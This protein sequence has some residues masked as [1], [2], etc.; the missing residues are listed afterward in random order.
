MATIDS[1]IQRAP[2]QYTLYMYINRTSNSV[3]QQY[4]ER[5]QTH[6]FN[7]INNEYA[8]SGFDILVP[9]EHELVPFEANKIDFNIKCEMVKMVNNTTT[10]SAFYL[11][12]RS[13]IS[14]TKF[15]LANNVGIIDSGYR[16]NLI[17]M[18]DVLYS[19][20]PVKCE[21][22]TRL[23][24]ICTPTLEPF[25]IVMVESDNDLSTTIRGSG[26]LGSTGLTSFDV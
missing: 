1:V 7:V 22:G 25:K 6:N 9:K 16:G 11:Y 20:M 18:F 5:I 19:N 8:D 24:Q 4:D 12:P 14:K 23:L 17:G 13:S 21:K 15:R 3:F 26:G 2:I 10:P